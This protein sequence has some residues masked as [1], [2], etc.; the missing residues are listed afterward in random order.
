MCVA[1]VVFGEGD[2]IGVLER[3]RFPGYDNSFKG[4]QQYC[5]E[6]LAYNLTRKFKKAEFFR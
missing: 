1:E 3:D 6:H 4:K 5:F 2:H